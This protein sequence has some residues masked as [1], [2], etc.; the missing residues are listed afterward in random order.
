[1]SIEKINLNEKFA[2]LGERDYATGIVA[3]MN[4]YEIK[5][6]KFRGEFVWHKHSD[7]DETFIILDGAMIM[8]LMDRQV[9]VKAGEMIV[10][11][12]GVEHKPA[13]ING[14]KALL[15]EPEGIPNTATWITNSRFQNSNCFKRIIK[16]KF[17]TCV[18]LVQNW[19]VFIFL[20]KSAGSIQLWSGYCR[21]LS[22]ERCL[23][24]SAG[25][26]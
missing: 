22:F 6:V 21:N 7:T 23:T 26:K 16:I 12:R 18:Q 19:F 25:L 3:K 5:I 8:N 2:K 1:M 20:P 17:D 9:E 11:P 24:T 4:N 10:I 13:S 14:Y 15:I